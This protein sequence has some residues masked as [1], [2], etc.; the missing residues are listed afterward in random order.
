M[1]LANAQLVGVSFTAMGSPCN[2]KIFVK[3]RLEGH[4]VLLRVAK[5]IQRLDNKYSRYKSDLS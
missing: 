1:N 4:D 5:E 2:V 3:K